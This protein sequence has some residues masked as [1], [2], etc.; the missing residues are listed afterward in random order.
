[1]PSRP[2]V[3][4]YFDIRPAIK[5]LDNEQKGQLF[6]AIL[7][8]GEYGNLPD[9][10]DPLLSMAWAFTLPRIDRDAEAYDD[11]IEQRRYAGYCSASRK[12]KIEPI[13]YDEWKELTEEARKQL[14]TDSGKGAETN[15]K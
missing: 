14:I 10:T 13:S 6:D 2:G 4:F 8:Y 11:K 7:E 12:K 3:M 1:M 9:F 5:F 15:G